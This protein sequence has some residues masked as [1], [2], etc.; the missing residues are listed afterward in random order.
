MQ[1]RD[2][3]KRLKSQQAWDDSSIF[4]FTSLSFR[5]QKFIQ[6]SCFLFLLLDL[7]LF[8]GFLLKCKILTHTLPNPVGIETTPKPTVWILR[9]T[10][11][12]N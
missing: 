7:F 10:R 11:G 6:N 9:V 8:V 4:T 12:T 3:A 1:L 2:T 5:Y